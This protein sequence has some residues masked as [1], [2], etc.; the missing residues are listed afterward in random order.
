MHFRVV[1]EVEVKKQKIKESKTL[2]IDLF[3]NGK[4]TT[5]GIDHYLGSYKYEDCKKL[6]A[7]DSRAV[8]YNP[9]NNAEKANFEKA[10]DLKL[11]HASIIS[12]LDQE[13]NQIFFSTLEYGG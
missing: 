5:D 12:V 8:W 6:F 7:E 11:Y 2:W 10:I 13:G 3:V 9:S 4:N 1:N